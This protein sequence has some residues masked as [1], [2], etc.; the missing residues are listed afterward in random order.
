MPEVKLIDRSIYPL[1]EDRVPQLL[2]D[3]RRPQGAKD[4]VLVAADTIEGQLLELRPLREDN[5]ILKSQVEWLC[6]KIH[7]LRAA[8]EQK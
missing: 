7:D 3:L 8:K 5:A 1:S 4:W 6:E 2:D